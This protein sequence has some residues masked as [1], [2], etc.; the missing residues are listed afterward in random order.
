MSRQS[1]AGGQSSLPRPSTTT[2]TARASNTQPTYDFLTGGEENPLPLRKSSLRQS[3]VVRS[4][5]I[6]HD[7]IRAQ[8]HAREYELQQLRQER[9]LLTLQHDKELRDVQIRAEADYKKFSTSEAAIRKANQRGDGLARELQETQHRAVNEKT[10]LERRLRDLQEQNGS[11]Q[12]DA[13]EYEARLSD[14]ERQYKFQIEDVETKRKTLQDTLDQMQLDLQRWKQTSDEAQQNMTQRNRD[15]EDLEAQILDLKSRS[16]DGDA[17]AIVQRELSEQVNHIRKLEATNREQLSELRRLRND[18]KNV[19]VVEDQKRSLQTELDVLKDVQ[20]QLGEAQMQK[21][22]LEDERR[23]WTTLLQRDG[24]EAE[25]DSPEA[26]IRALVQERIEHASLLD[27]LGKVDADSSE[28]DEMIKTLEQERNNL[29]AAAS[30]RIQPHQ[31]GTDEAP[32]AKAFKRLERQ[33]NLM[34]KE[35]DYLRAQLKAFEQEESMLGGEENKQEPQHAEQIKHLEALIDQHRSEAQQLASE[36]SKLESD[37]SQKHPSTTAIVGNK[38]PA[39]DDTNSQLGALLRKNKNLQSAL[40]G[41]SSKYNLSQIELSSTKSQLKTLQARLREPRILAINKNPT[42]DFE[43]IKL[44]TIRAL[45][46]ENKALLAQ[47][48]G[49]DFSDSSIEMLPKATIEALHFELEEKEHTIREKEK[50]MSRLKEIWTNKATEFR[51]L[52]VSILGYKVDFM[53][54]GKVRVTN[55]YH[56]N[57]PSVASGGISKEDAASLAEENSIVFDGDAGTMKI[58]GGNSS[59]FALEIQDLVKFW[60]QERGEIPCFLAAMTL[61]NY[62]KMQGQQQGSE[63]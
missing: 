56:L 23:A 53:P 10:S 48:T 63:T 31:G 33:N 41:M 45:R 49:Q 11:Y 36:L 60:V 25:F 57:H 8:L 26:L 19:L 13:E 38:R 16:G 5:P 28:K 18:A 58:A 27:R 44:S 55:T 3:Q 61:E 1:L 54:N 51:D 17:L 22:I 52:I 2:A 9:E 50:R 4:E 29:K 20:R 30:K 46:A 39:E 34:L 15:V 7:D 59:P 35:V 47:I 24:E 21:E 42:T 40:A 14:Q 37:Q 62:E 12:E 32:D 6:G 43:V